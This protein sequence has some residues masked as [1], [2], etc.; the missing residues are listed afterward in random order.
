MPHPLILTIVNICLIHDHTTWL[1]EIPIFR[2]Q[3]SVGQ[4]V[5]HI[6][7]SLQQGN[8]ETH[9]TSNG[10]NILCELLDEVVV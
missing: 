8:L 6:F 7:T 9:R 1:V 4:K 2:F 10:V 5:G 3:Q